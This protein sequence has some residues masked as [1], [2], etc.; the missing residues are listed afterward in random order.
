MAPDLYKLIA[1]RWTSGVSVVTVYED[2]YPVGAAISAVMPLSLSPAQFAISLA[3]SSATLAAIRRSSCFCINILSRDQKDYCRRFSGP[4]EERFEGLEYKLGK[5]GVPVLGDTV[6][7]MECELVSDH[8]SGDHFI[9]VGAAR[10]GAANDREPL[11]Y[12]GSRFWTLAQ[13]A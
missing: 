2:D 11:G 5:L 13:C 7:H 8:A 10:A 12:F 6:A 4:R 3:A 1:S 9:L